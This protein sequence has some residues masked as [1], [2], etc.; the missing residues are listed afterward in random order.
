MGVG[1]HIYELLGSA[2][3]VVELELLDRVHFVAEPSEAAHYTAAFEQASKCALDA[4]RS[5]EFLREL[6][7]SG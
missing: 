1:F 7:L 3:P 6:A 2:A 5:S 4:E